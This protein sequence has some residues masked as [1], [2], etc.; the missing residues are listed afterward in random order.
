MQEASAD[1][2]FATSY[3]ISFMF[4]ATTKVGGEERGV[5]VALEP[6]IRKMVQNQIRMGA[7]KDG[8]SGFIKLASD[9]TA[10]TKK[11]TATATTV[12]V[13]NDSKAL[14]IGTIALVFAGE[15]YEVSTGFT[16]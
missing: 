3:F 13:G 14:Q 9:G 11:E 8:D 16:K 1:L 7:L 5:R 4:F 10:I 6:E 2:R 15:T 12:T